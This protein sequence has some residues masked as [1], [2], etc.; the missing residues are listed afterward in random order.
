MV[1]NCS[2]ACRDWGLASPGLRRVFIVAGSLSLFSPAST[3]WGE[4]GVP[5]AL[6]FSPASPQVQGPSSPDSSEA[7]HAGNGLEVGLQTRME[8]GA[9]VLEGG[10]RVLEAIAGEHAHHPGAA[11]DL[12]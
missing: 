7:E 4:Q 5:R 3:T 11:R 6:R 2:W 9:A 10:A 8:A 12:L 1:E